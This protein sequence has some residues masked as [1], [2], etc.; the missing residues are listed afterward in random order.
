MFIEFV[1]GCSVRFTHANRHCPD[2][3]HSKLLRDDQG[4]LEGLLA[5]TPRQDSAIVQ[6]LDKYVRSR[7]ESFCL[8]N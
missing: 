8:Y 2:H 6:W 7:H 5:G 3:P 1:S 4:A